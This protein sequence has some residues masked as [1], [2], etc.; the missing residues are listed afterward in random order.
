MQP[1]DT[2][3]SYTLLL[4]EYTLP[5]EFALTPQTEMR[6]QGCEQPHVP[7]DAEEMVQDVKSGLVWDLSQPKGDEV[8]EWF[9]AFLL[10][11]SYY[12]TQA[13]IQLIHLM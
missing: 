13:Q 7:Y 11:W 12:R 8:Y 1:T 6:D 4:P 3:Q 10:F 5:L 2:N 9:E